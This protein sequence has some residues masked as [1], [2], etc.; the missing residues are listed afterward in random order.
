MI[1]AADAAPRVHKRK[2]SHIVTEIPAGGVAVALDPVAKASNA[3]YIARGKTEEEKKLSEEFRNGMIIEDPLGSYTLKRLFFS[4]EETNFYYYGFSN[5]TLWPL[6][7][8]AFEGPEFRKDWFDGFKRVNQ[9][10]ASAIKDEIKGKTFIWVNDY[11]LS[12][13]PRYLGKPRG[14][15]VAMF[16]H[17]PWPTWEVFRILPFKKEL[18]E[19]MLM[20]D[21]IGFHRGYQVRNFLDTVKRELEVRIDEETNKIYYNKNVTVVKNLPLGIDTDVIESLAQEKQG[22]EFLSRFLPKIVPFIK[23]NEK[24]ADLFA[25]HRVLLGVDRLDYTK[26]L[27]VRLLALDRLFTKYPGYMGNVVYVGILAP[28]REAIPAY[29]NLKKEIREMAEQIN[30]KYRKSHWQPIH[31]FSQIFKRQEIV[32]LYRQA[33]VCIVTPLDDGMNLVS[34]EF[35]ITSALSSDPGMLVLSQFAGSATDL[36]QALI[37]N[38][39]DIEEVVDA[40]K[41]GLEMDKREK[42]NR[43]KQMAETLR[44]RNI[45]VWTE[46]FI[47]SATM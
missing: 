36:A 29:K 39:Y 25:K 17:I 21:F 35:V 40:I 42:V 1:I 30:D 11:Q 2:N 7:H 34:K 15:T 16:W 14:T 3:T 5:Q 23:E 33:D 28:S 20:C 37:V 24:F 6:C 10:F 18:L 27:R 38:P 43:I 12:M 45:Y 46:D 32:N 9:R 4:P 31:L 47:R 41:R 13:V 19:S 8:V 22:K 26:G 44:Q